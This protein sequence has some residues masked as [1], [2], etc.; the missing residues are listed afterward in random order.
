MQTSESIFSQKPGCEVIHLVY[1]SEFSRSFSRARFSCVF[2]FM[3]GPLDRGPDM[4]STAGSTLQPLHT[5]VYVAV[6]HSIDGHKTS[7]ALLVPSSDFI[8]NLCAPLALQREQ[9][10]SSGLGVQ[11]GMPWQR[12]CIHSPQQSHAIMRSPSSSRHPHTH[13]TCQ[14]SSPPAFTIA[15]SYANTVLLKIS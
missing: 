15:T 4:H 9:I 2:V 10:N 1:R 12:R 8:I 14:S 7:P 6:L 13:E 11:S 5:D 3:P